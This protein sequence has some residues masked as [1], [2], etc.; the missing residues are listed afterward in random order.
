[1]HLWLLLFCNNCHTCMLNP[2]EA[3]PQAVGSCDGCIGYPSRG[4]SFT[5]L[6]LR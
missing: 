3:L 5:A 2:R 1:M 4:S 6:L